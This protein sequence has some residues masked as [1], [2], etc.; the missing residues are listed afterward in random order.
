LPVVHVPRD[1]DGLDSRTAAP[2]STR[3]QPRS[4]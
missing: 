2:V 3:Q 1:A 4:S